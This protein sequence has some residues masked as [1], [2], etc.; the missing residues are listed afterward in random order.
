MGDR[1]S[2]GAG[3]GSVPCVDGCVVDGGDAETVEC[4][5]CNNDVGA[6]ARDSRLGLQHMEWWS[7]GATAVLSASTKRIEAA[8]SRNLRMLICAGS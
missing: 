5:T 7:C 4:F 1:D 8:A 6:A 2:C 3:V